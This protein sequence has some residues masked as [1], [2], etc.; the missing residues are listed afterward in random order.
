MTTA[1][2]TASSNTGA[3]ALDADAM[4]RRGFSFRLAFAI[5]ASAPA[6]LVT[7]APW[8][9]VWL[10]AVFV[11]EMWLGAFL[12]NTFVWPAYKRAPDVAN[13]RQ[14]A[15]IGLG[16][17]IFGAFPFLTWN[18]NEVVGAILALAWMGGTAIH[19]F[20]YLSNHRLLLA[21]G[22]VPPLAAAAMLPSLQLG[23]TLEALASS[24]AALYLIAAAGVFA[25]DRNDLLVQ[26]TAE[27]AGREAAETTA[28]AKSAFLNAVTHELR[29]PINHI[30][31]YAGLLEEDIKSGLADP[32]DAASIAGAGQSLLVL[33]NRV[34][35][36]SRLESGAIAL[37][38]DDV[39]VSY[40][41]TQAAEQIAVNASKSGNQVVVDPG[42]L[43]TSIRADAERVL[44]CLRCFSEHAATSWPNGLV[45]FTANR[46]GENIDLTVMHTGPGIAGDGRSDIFARADVSSLGEHD[47][48]DL[49]LTLANS[50]AR[51]MGGSV[52]SESTLGIV[53]RF[54]LRLPA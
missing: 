29:T 30:V 37:D 39:E 44:E 1:F 33:V 21:V 35:D 53:T 8:L 45:T 17:L 26:V 23:F 20:I 5:L 22:L 46:V 9:L 47:T 3:S 24:V 38:V 11:W 28:Q 32:S 50:L 4:S 27:K 34:I 41:L 36:I 19:V 49:G 10:T 25:T 42:A 48:E 16:A 31:G 40:L 18:S 54:T 7:P 15:V 12:T 14:A 13:K 51:A 6:L 43:K 2:P 52:R